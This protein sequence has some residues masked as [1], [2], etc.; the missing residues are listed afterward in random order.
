M[1][2]RS[3]DQKAF[4]QLMA[5][6]Q[7]PEA[8]AAMAKMMPPTPEI[9]N[10]PAAE[11][12][13]RLEGQVAIITG[14]AS[15]IGKASV[16]LFLREGAKVVAGDLNEQGLAALKEEFAEFGDNLATF[17]VN[18]GVKENVEAM[19]DFAVETFGDLDVVFNNAGIIDNM[20]TVEDMD[21]ATYER[22]MSVNTNSVFYSSRKAVKYFVDHDKGGVILN[23]ASISGLCGCRGGFAYTAS[24]HA[25]VG[26]TKNIAYMFGGKGIRC[27]AICPGG[28]M[29][30]IGNTIT[31]PSALGYVQSQRGN[32]LMDRL[33]DPYEIAAAAVFLCTY[34]AQFINGTTLTVDGGWSAY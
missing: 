32:S 31:A 12:G 22:V 34:D 28:I 25:V 20:K 10:K 30:N 16:D 9:T 6:T 18:V 14:A 27:N 2:D 29:T 15:G 13:N 8:A 3:E 33:G 17:R 21:D 26:M 1:A 7:S 11:R 24:K 4:E 5:Q 19:I 23:T